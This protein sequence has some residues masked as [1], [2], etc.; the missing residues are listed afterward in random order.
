LPA[1][2]ADDNLAEG[3]RRWAER[4]PDR[5]ALWADGALWSYGELARRA[6]AVAAAIHAAI[7]DPVGRAVAIYGGRSAEAHAALL[8]VL[9]SGATAV[10]LTVRT[11]PARLAAMLEATAPAAVVVDEAGEA[12]AGAPLPALRLRAADAPPSDMAPARLS[13]TARPYAVFTSGTT[14]RPKC[15]APEMGAANAFLAAMQTLFAFGPEDRTGP[16]FDLD[17]DPFLINL[18]A[19]WRAGG[20]VH[21][22]AEGR[23]LDAARFIAEQGITVWYCQPSLAAMLS[24]VHKLRPGALPSLRLT[25]FGAET[26]TAGVAEAWRAAAPNSRIVNYY[27]PTET[28]VACSQHEW[29]GPRDL[30]PGRD[31]VAIGRPFP[32]VTMAT[33]DED[34]RFLPD[35]AVGEIAVAGRQL[36]PDYWRQPDATAARFRTVAGARWY[37][38]GD[39]G[40][41]DASG[42]WHFL[43]R[44][45]HQVQV[46]GHR[47]ELDEVET[48]LRR[49]SG[50]EVVAVVPW[51]VVDSRV[52]GL[53]G[54]VETAAIDAGAVAAVLRG[55]LPP[56]AIP[57]RL[58]SMPLLPR[59][60]TGKVDRAA[61]VAMLDG[62]G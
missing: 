19:T 46:L 38:T 4:A 48:A 50:C 23:G 1:I 22:L 41:R 47:V 58:Q 43:G 17:F 42:V 56:H 16:C 55:M 26:L 27:G 13:E 40:F 52:E 60:A 14:G 37:L 33:V 51:P 28:T 6:A 45:D 20:C 5:P 18:F 44:A 57:R 11:P 2:P 36:A 61:L 34:G 29:R 31:A 49:A 15:V 54:F 24:R 10:P 25:L 62:A 21:V 9:W 35:G 32:G 30:T 3:V 39:R 53:V 59:G 7:G 12:Q 8:G